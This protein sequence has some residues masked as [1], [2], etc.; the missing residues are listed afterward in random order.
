MGQQ[1]RPKSCVTFRKTDEIL[2]HW[3]IFINTH[4]LETLIDFLFGKLRY[5]FIL[6]LVSDELLSNDIK[7]RQKPVKVILEEYFIL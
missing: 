7:K 5:R 6:W 3:P 1:T 2:E 4:F